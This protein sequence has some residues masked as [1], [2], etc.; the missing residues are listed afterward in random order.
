MGS[1]KALRKNMKVPWMDVCRELEFTEEQL[2][3]AQSILLKQVAPYIREGRMLKNSSI[4][5]RRRG[6]GS[7]HTPRLGYEAVWQVSAMVNN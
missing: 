2:S 5:Y 4:L 7:A 1:N 6:N 3:G